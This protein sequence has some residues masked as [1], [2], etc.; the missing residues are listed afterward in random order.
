MPV[1]ARWLREV[2]RELGQFKDERFQVRASISA[3]DPQDRPIKNAEAR[4]LRCILG[5]W[6]AQCEYE[7]V[8]ALAGALCRRREHGLLRGRGPKV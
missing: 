3:V 4:S 6:L 8:S 1:G 5:G 2:L 7:Q